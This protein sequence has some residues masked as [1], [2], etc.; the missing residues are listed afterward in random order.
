[1]QDRWHW[2]VR[3]VM[4]L[5]LY[6]ICLI[7]FDLSQF[8]EPDNKGHTARTLE[9]TAKSYLGAA[10]LEREAA[11]LLLAR[12]YVR[13]AVKNIFNLHALTF[14]FCQEGHGFRIPR[15]L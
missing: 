11:A 7:P 13:Y 10:G 6:I 3:Y 4:L 14:G 2:A 1:M 15:L 8:D 5:W 12:L 9:A